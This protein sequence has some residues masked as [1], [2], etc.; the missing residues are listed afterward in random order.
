M[1]ESRHWLN[2]VLTWRW[3]VIFSPPV[4]VDLPERNDILSLDEY[5]SRNDLA[6]RPLL[7]D[8]ESFVYGNVL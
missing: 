1:M 3:V 5:S 4:V 8:S 2:Q 6:C 7:P